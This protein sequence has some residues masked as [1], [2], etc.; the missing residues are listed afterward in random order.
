MAGIVVY[1]LYFSKSNRYFQEK[2]GRKAIVAVCSLAQ[3]SMDFEGNLRRILESVKIAKEYG[4]KLVT[5][6]FCITETKSLGITA[7]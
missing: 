2:M 5:T 1:F 7:L 3:W 4:G 6:N